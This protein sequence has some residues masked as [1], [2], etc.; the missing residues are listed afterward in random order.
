[1]SRRRA[2]FLDTTVFVDLILV[3]RIRDTDRGEMTTTR[4]VR[5]PFLVALFLAWYWSRRPG[6]GQRLRWFYEGAALRLALLCLGVARWKSTY[7]LL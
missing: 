5:I 6:L 4:P 7:I 2:T 1:M 3:T